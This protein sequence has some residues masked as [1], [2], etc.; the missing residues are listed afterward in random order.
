MS[1]GK[2]SEIDYAAVPSRANL[3]YSEAFIRRD[4]E[5]RLAYLAGL[6]RG[7]T[8]IN[9]DVLFPHDIVHKYQDGCSHGWYN[10]T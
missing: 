7:E 3:L 9:A 10:I 2:W 1:G 8:K 5:R 4:E 6:Q